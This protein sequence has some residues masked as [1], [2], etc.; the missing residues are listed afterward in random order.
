M[1]VTR[2]EDVRRGRNS[3]IMLGGDKGG[4]RDFAFI[5]WLETIKTLLLN[6][7]TIFI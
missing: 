1:Q 6:D 3:G 7:L 4:R 2:T 5:W